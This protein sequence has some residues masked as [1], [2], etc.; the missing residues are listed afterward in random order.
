M[1]ESYSAH[2]AGSTFAFACWRLCTDAPLT[3]SSTNRASRSGDIM[4]CWYVWHR[5][6]RSIGTILSL[7]GIVSADKVS[8]LSVNDDVR[9]KIVP[10]Q[11]V[12]H[13]SQLAGTDS[14]HP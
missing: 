3:A 11:G 9:V 8:Q 12:S 4:H 10:L 2:R 6:I 5:N 14:G 13:C 1:G 7:R